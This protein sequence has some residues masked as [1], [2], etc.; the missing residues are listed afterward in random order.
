M[1]KNYPPFGTGKDANVEETNRL[2]GSPKGNATGHFSVQATSLK[3]YLFVLMLTMVSMQSFAQYVRST[4]STTY[5]PITTG[6]G[7]TQLAS[8][9]TIG[10]F[11]SSSGT[12]GTDDAAALIQLPFAFTYNSVAFTTSHYVNICTNGYLSL[13][14]GN[15]NSAKITAASS[16]NLFSTSAPNVTIAG[17]LDDLDVG[18]GSGKV[19]YQTQ[20][21]VGS[22][23]FTVQYEN[24]RT[25]Y[26][27]AT[28]TINF[29]IILYET[30]NVIELKY[31]TATNLIH[32]TAQIESA[33][34]GIEW[35]TG[36]SGNYIDAF[37]GSKTLG[38]TLFNSENF[39]ASTIGYRFTPGTPTAIAAGSYNVG[40]GQTYPTLSEA[41]ADV[42]HR[43][44]SGA[45]TFNC[46]DASYPASTGNIYPMLLSTI[47][48]ASASNTVTINGNGAV[49]SYRGV[50]GGSIFVGATTL[51]TSGALPMVGL[52]GSDYVTFRNFTTNLSAAAPGTTA[53]LVPVSRGVLV[54][55]ATAT[56]GATNNTIRNISASLDRTNTSSIAV[57]QL[58]NVTPSSALG[59]N[60]N[61]KYYNL[62]LS[63]AY[64]GI[65]LSGN[66]SFPD[67]GSEIGVTGG[68]TSTIGG[69]TANDIG[70][71]SSQ[72]FGI[73]A[74]NQSGCKIF[75]NEVRNVTVSGSVLSDGIFL[76]S[77]V[78]SNEIYNN[79]VHDI[80]NAST[81]ATTGISGIRYSYNTTGTNNVRVYNNFV[82]GLTS[83]Y[84]G[85]ASATRQIKGIHSAGTGGSTSQSDNVE[86][87]SVRIDGSGSANISSTCYEIASTTP[88]HTLRNNILANAT[89]AQ[90]GVAKHYAVVTTSGSSI[91]G[92]GTVWNRN[93][94]YIANAT[95]GFTGLGNTTD[96]A[97]LA[98]W[99]AHT[100][101][102]DANSFSQ[103]PQFNSATDLK[104]NPA[105]ATPV[106]GGG[107][108]FSGAITWVPNDKEGDVRNATTP[109][110][111][112]DEGT[113]TPL[114]SNDM[115]ATAF[116]VPLNGATISGGSTVTPQAS[117][118]NNGLNPQTAVTVRYRIL[119]PSSVEVYNQTASIASIASGATTTVTFPVSSALSTPGTYT[120]FA[121][122][123]LGT[124]TVGAN[125]EISGSFT[126]L[127]P[128]AGDYLV[129]TAQ[130]AP[131]NTLPSA[132]AMLN[133]AG[134]SAATRF[135]LTDASYNLGATPLQINTI[136]GSSPAN[137]F[138]IKPN[139]GVTAAITANVSTATIIIN[140]ADNVII[141]GSNGVSNNAVCPLSVATRDLTI[142]NTNTGTSS[143]V[144][145]LQNNV[146][147]GATSNIVRNCNL[148]GSGVTQTLIGVG[149]GSNSISISSSGTGNNGNTFEN[150]NISGVQYGIYSQGASAGS[151]NTGT[152][153][154]QNV[155]TTSANTRGGILVG[156]EDGITISGN[157][158]SN[159]AQAGSPDVFGIAVGMSAIANTT[160]AGNDV[161]NAT[162]TNNVIGSVVNSGTFSAAGIAVAAVASG[163][164]LIANNTISGVSANG[165]SGDFGAGIILGG[166]AGST[167]NVFHNTV[168]MQGTIPGGTAATQTS[169]CLAVTNATASTLNIKNNIFT[170]T[171]LGNSGASVRMTA[172]ALGYSTYTSL[173]TN[174]ND[175]YAAGAG[176]G[177]Y[178]IGITGG[179]TSG[180]SSATLA[181]WQSTTGKET[182]SKNVL[183]I[184]TSTT[185]LHLNA[186]N[187]TNAALDAAGD[188]TAGITTDI[189][190]AT[191]G[192][193]PDIGADE[194]T[195]PACSDASGGTATG[196]IAF[197]VSGT[198]TIAASGYSSGTGSG[199]K[200]ISSTNIGDYP[201][202][203]TETGQTNPASLTTGV[204]STTTYYW[205]RVTCATNT[206]TANSNMVTVT[207][208]P[209]PA[210]V[211]VN[212]AGTF[213]TNT[214]ITASNGN[215]GTIYFQGTTSGGV[216][217]ATPSASQVVSA[218]GTYYFRAQNPTTLCWGA[219]GSVIVTIQAPAG[220]T[221]T[222]AVT[223]VNGTASLAASATNCT[224][225]ANSGTTIS[226]AWNSVT[227][228]I[229]K[230]PTTPLADT[231]T[232]GF[233]A[234]I[235]RNY[236]STPFQ[237][238]ATGS[239]TFEMND[240]LA[241]DGMAYITTGAFVPGTCPGAG[242]WIKGD[243][244]GGVDDE[245][246]M[247][248]TLT[249]GVTYNLISTTWASSSGTYSGP[250]GWTIT[251]PASQQIMLSAP[252][253]IEWYTAASGGTAIGTG[254]PFNPVG[255]AGS[256]LNNTATA[257]TTI[258]YAACSSSN[259]CRTPV[260]F[261]INP[262][263]TVNVGGAVTAI[264][265][266]GTTAVLGGS[267]GGSA[268][269]AVWSDGGAGGTFANN[270]GTT[271]GTATYTAS[272]TSTSP[273]TL[274]LTTSG[275]SCGTTSANKQ[276]TVNTG[277]TYYADT[278]SDGFGDPAS[279]AIFCG[280]APAGYVANNTDCA[281]ADGTKW[282]TGNF[283]VDA[284]NDGYY[285]GNPT[286][287]S[288]CYGAA[289]PSG[290]TASIIG[291]DCDDA[292]A[293]ANPNHVEIPGNTIDDNCDG[294]AD[295]AGPVIGMIPSQCG[296]TMSNIAA[297]IYSQQA[298]GAE[299]YRFE[300]TN[301]SNVRTYDSATNSFSL[302][303]LPGGVLYA[304]TY[305]IRV[306][307][308]TAGF[309]RSYS[310]S[311]NI[312]TPSAP[313]T[314]VVIASQ[315]GTTLANI[316]NLIYCNQVT[317]ANQYRF[318][319]TDGV[320]P[321]R[322]FD[323]SVNRFSL[324]NLAG[325]ATYGVTYSVRVALRFGATW[326]PYGTACNITTPATP[327]VTSL[328]AS[329]CGITISNRWVSL[330]ANQVPDAQGYRFEVSDGVTTRFVDRA[331]SNFALGQV[332]GGVSANTVYTVRV[333]VLYNS[334]YGAFGAP[335]TVTTSA[336]F[337]RQAAAPV[338][339]FEVKTY[340]NPFAATFKLDIN[341]SSEALVS[342][343]VY[344]MI[345]K[346]VE[347]HEINATELGTQ[348][349]GNRYSSGVYNVIVSQ[350][351]N[352]ETLRVIKR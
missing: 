109:D 183:A 320:N 248:A 157:S 77:Y 276:V 98:N 120:I 289:A 100:A 130:A 173:T 214:T 336:G 311:C 239:Y 43:G 103:N 104:I 166:G 26:Q 33:C 21:S 29:Q 216:S 241:F 309:Y 319:V 151:K 277:T 344:D 286:P 280:A 340:P 236:V 114:I 107:S 118:T 274:T 40:S 94:L 306:A 339:V 122:A 249:V 193:T 163:T 37:T 87:N 95:N 182:N 49:L 17:W 233:D 127:A 72:T 56:D 275:G 31:G 19:L 16:D 132:I 61:N 201:N 221:G 246:K 146:A 51:S 196:S 195:P 137:T 152:K 62:S 24:V 80:R 346:L 106:E 255:V 181:N 215:D 75:N 328:I 150:N 316:A 116:V 96:Y 194:F 136:A 268:T 321:A 67:V 84:T 124:D 54:T 86:F 203:G 350:G 323:T 126:V 170:N 89:G 231:T 8:G 190:C 71:G 302:V 220:I 119:N 270:S 144:V 85:S 222:D 177:T 47:A 330:Y 142:S 101:A 281:P 76:E 351:E 242:T 261:V 92:T 258:F 197:C 7:A 128:L 237:V 134:V 172:I 108:Y 34:A 55:N 139:T 326:E 135:L 164:T 131:Y 70:N 113:F 52:V 154:N 265:Q 6:T 133:A 141:A 15:T 294:T 308:K 3:S 205:L 155:I 254:S 317:A 53:F 5:T 298:S 22:R 175:L 301:G 97:T 2:Y 288:L 66:S 310:G 28:S 260:N 58:I 191:R 256:G 318:E 158:I 149:S 27:T 278:D 325:G 235:T 99:Q 64:S 293:N 305:S 68:G 30:S 188:A 156:Y 267:F 334:V 218:S 224:A 169:A 307:V 223:C 284:D 250:F 300:V 225:F 105:V 189:D 262:L 219:E 42:N 273:V 279:S 342:V 125:D 91:G 41:I 18:L 171:Q 229:A 238:T 327:G 332:A 140:G 232:C 45:V 117:F 253:T 50:Y 176:P 226:G 208:N 187:A 145:W 243:D 213:C 9:T 245:P 60:S 352:V 179:V 32:N 343:K 292:N 228:P 185:D 349:L 23:T 287:V 290:Y 73:R 269:A 82:Y 121:K 115:Q 46:T 199:Y 65:Y 271:P 102:P 315:C 174:N 25:Y 204:V 285:N 93:V 1:N 161:T 312:T 322:T 160:S 14:T 11:S 123:E 337:S 81:S 138:M 341:T 230:R 112:A 192:A 180:T 266:G 186:S 38:A 200:W 153:I 251:P 345:G 291:T 335:C 227:D 240:N 282:Q 162:V 264:C 217:T 12:A 348:E 211:V 247:T 69:A 198:P 74:S 90:T 167:T 83:G 210:T 10:T 110:I 297:T 143:A 234:T 148:T 272:P 79:S 314:T 129:G 178:A 324:T 159:I 78:G 63:N 202:G 313:A 329:Q 48:G 244:D 207:I 347:S 263:P 331:V 295:E 252:G 168:A 299:G 209:L 212:G 333:A 35:G 184:Y 296:T 257:G 165:T 57:Q 303:N 259:V 4:F 13:V 338:T 206:S 88:V 283:Y 304:T 36:G 39:P 20:G 59:A 44:V 111:G 147:D